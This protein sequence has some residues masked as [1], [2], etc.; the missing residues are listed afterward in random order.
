MIFFKLWIFPYGSTT[1]CH[2]LSRILVCTAD[3]QETSPKTLNRNPRD[4]VFGTITNLFLRPQVLNIFPFVVCEN[5]ATLAS[6]CDRQKE[7]ILTPRTSFT[8]SRKWFLTKNDQTQP[9]HRRRCRIT[10]GHS[11]THLN[12]FKAG[13]HTCLKART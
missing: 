8:F 5:P 13:K 1:K 11:E 10:S 2:F 7:N 12:T 6:F 4:W 3:A 9:D